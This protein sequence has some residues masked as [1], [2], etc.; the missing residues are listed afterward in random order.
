[1]NSKKV[2]FVGWILCGLMLT[3]SIL[4]LS[5]KRADVAVPSIR[6]SGPTGASI[7]S[8]L[9]HKRGYKIS[10]TISTNPKLDQDSVLV[11]FVHPNEIVD[12]GSFDQLG[13]RSE[14]IE[15]I[16]VH[17]EKG[18]LAF[19][20]G[21]LNSLAEMRRTASKVTSV[22]KQVAGPIRKY[23]VEG[24]LDSVLPEVYAETEFTFL[25]RAIFIDE[26]TSAVLLNAQSNRKGVVF[27]SA[28]GY[29]AM[30]SMIGRGDNALLLVE[31]FT[32]FVPKDRPLVFLE[33]ALPGSE[34]ETLFGGIGP[35]MSAIS[36]QFF[37]FLFALAWHH[38]RG[39][40]PPVVDRLREKG[41]RDLLEAVG[42]AMER[43]NMR[44]I[45]GE[46]FEREAMIR[47]R[48]LIRAGRKESNASVLERI[49]EDL[50]LA[51]QEAK[52]SVHQLNQETVQRA[53][54][55]FFELLSSRETRRQKRVE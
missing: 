34:T 39:F 29:A 14:L 51:L 2:L 15:F 18:G 28:L 48:K 24:F 20:L 35:W 1:M 13:K 11:M 42:F 44:G 16:K 25:N 33:G 50:R 55:H 4:Y 47:L 36:A 27:N 31:S 8:E 3:A 26:Q 6:N 46:L 38:W 30:N 40:G 32:R 23:E 49:P 53:W 54:G 19:Q 5:V 9:L 12:I 10:R 7:L 17:T 52:G 45:A 37:F 22:G 41:A 43:G 21:T